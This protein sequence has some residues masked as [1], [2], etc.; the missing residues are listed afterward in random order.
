MPWQDDYK[1]KLTTAEEA[2]SIVADGDR[3]VVPLSEQ[4][5]TLLNA[6]AERAHEVKGA[7]LSIAVPQ[8]DLGP[9]LDAGWNV[10]IENFIGPY[11]RP[12][13]NEGRAPYSPLA[14]SL[15]FKAVDERP[16]E[17]KPVDVALVTVAPPNR[18]GQITFGPQAWYKRG[19]AQRAR[20]V[21]AEVNPSLIR[22]YGDSLHA[23]R[24][25]RQDGRSQPVQREPRVAHEDCLRLCP[26]TAGSRWRRS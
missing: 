9:F 26:T 22:T 10:D 18:Q 17:S 15:T 25:H 11:G 23:S 13:E 8:V 21:A 5:T 6:L 14:F 3:V 4:P 24:R 2:V 19:F 1:S 16:T 12:Y 7:T 20:K